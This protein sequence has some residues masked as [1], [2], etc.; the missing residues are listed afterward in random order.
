MLGSW[1]T[2]LQEQ[3][4]KMRAEM[5]ADEKQR[6]HQSKSIR[7][8]SSFT[9]PRLIG[10]RRKTP[11]LAHDQPLSAGGNVAD[12]DDQKSTLR[13]N[14]AQHISVSARCIVISRSFSLSFY[15]LLSLFY[16]KLSYFLIIMSCTTTTTTQIT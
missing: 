9:L 14:T 15:L 2:C 8:S 3:L 16:H 1:S 13:H 7:Q 12:D 4:E 5:A 10:F 6:K 11:S